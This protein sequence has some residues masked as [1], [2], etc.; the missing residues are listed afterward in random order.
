MRRPFDALKNAAAY[1]LA[2]PRVFLV[3]GMHRSGT[4]CVT[5]VLSLMGASLGPVG[6]DLVPGSDEQHWESWEV[7]WINEEMLR[8]SGGSWQN[9]PAAL[10]PVSRDRWR[11]RQ[12][13]WQFAPARTAVMKDP[14]IMLTYPVWRP[15]LP[16]HR[17]VVS[18]R[19]PL[20]VAQSLA[21]RDGMTIDRGMQ[22]WATYN[23]SLL[24]S[25]PD[26]TPIHWVDFDAG[27][28]GIRR[29]VRDLAGIWG[30]RENPAAARYYD[31]KV[32]H[33]RMHG[34]L[35]ADIS[36]LYDDLRS[37]TS[38]AAEVRAAV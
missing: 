37:R 27:G 7:N 28:N 38:L 12:L 8:R 34:R 23:R 22:L 24:A 19:H 10:Q 3:T 14:R 4:S 9:P 29:M 15:L 20:D 32:H 17:L 6:E 33:H 21:R 18:I 13:L 25:V 36:D 1:Q 26:N 31:P 30:L 16:T 2:P 35:P 11:C 5:R